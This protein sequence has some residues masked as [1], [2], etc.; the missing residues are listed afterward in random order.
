MWRCV[1]HDYD[2]DYDY[3]YDLCIMFSAVMV[4]LLISE[5]YY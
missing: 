4:S 1:Y 2:Y 3:D 5:G